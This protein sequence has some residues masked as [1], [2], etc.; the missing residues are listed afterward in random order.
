MLRSTQHYLTQSH[1]LLKQWRK[2]IA[3][4]MSV[5]EAAETSDLVCRSSPLRAVLQRDR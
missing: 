3:Q 2:R 5:R 1:L 4:P